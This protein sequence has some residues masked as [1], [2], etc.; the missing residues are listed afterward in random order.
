MELS[1]AAS[2]KQRDTRKKEP[3]YV[4]ICTCSPCR[5]VPNALTTPCPAN[6]VSPLR[7][8]KSVGFTRKQAR[9]ARSSHYPRLLGCKPFARHRFIPFGVGIQPIELLPVSFGAKHIWTRE[10]SPG[11]ARADGGLTNNHWRRCAPSHRRVLAC[12]G[13]YGHTPDVPYRQAAQGGRGV[14]RRGCGR[15]W[16]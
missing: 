7:L 12:V 3:P 5:D 15:R 4:Q 1:F 16:G 14:L 11:D 8:P 9:S 10:H 2:G 6:E 13:P